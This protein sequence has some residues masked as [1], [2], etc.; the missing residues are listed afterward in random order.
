MQYTLIARCYPTSFVT[1]IVQQV[2]SFPFVLGGDHQV[3]DYSF[4]DE[5][6]AAVAMRELL[7]SKALVELN[8][9]DSDEVDRC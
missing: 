2:V 4:P 5:K 7:N 9:D 3:W 1:G 6:S 8:R